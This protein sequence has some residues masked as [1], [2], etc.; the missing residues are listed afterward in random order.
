MQFDISPPIAPPPL[1]AAMRH[2]LIR[3]LRATIRRDEY[4]AEARK[5]AGQPHSTLLDRIARSMADLAEL[6]AQI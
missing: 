2:N 3:G 4:S 6:E 5:L 1:T